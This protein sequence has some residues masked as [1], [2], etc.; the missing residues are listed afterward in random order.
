MDSDG[1]EGGWCLN[2]RYPSDYCFLVYLIYYLTCAVFF[3]S[4]KACHSWKPTILQDHKTSFVGHHIAWHIQVLFHFFYKT[5]CW[6]GA[7][8]WLAELL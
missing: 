2:A 7:I 6:K 4:Q 3:Y 8:L 5:H 1:E